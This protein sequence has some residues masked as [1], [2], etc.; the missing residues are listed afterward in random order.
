MRA[1][2]ALALIA[3]LAMLTACASEPRPTPDS[4]TT[5]ATG[6]A[7][8][9]PDDAAPTDPVAPSTQPDAAPPHTFHPEVGQCLDARKDRATGSESIVPCAE[10]HDDEVYATFTLEHGQYP[11]E[12]AAE[13]AA[14]DGCRARFA[15]FIGVAHGDSVF[16][17]YSVYPSARSWNDQGDRTVTCL[18]WYPA[19]TVVGSLEGA[20]Y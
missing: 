18:V 8:G 14:N 12:A 7:T 2:G 16:E 3:A 13:M 11:G 20:G 6:L 5:S 17:F 9:L 15:D 10:P 4:A 19:D 1:A